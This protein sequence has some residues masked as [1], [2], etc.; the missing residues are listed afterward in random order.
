MIAD[1]I[2]ELRL[3]NGIKQT[4]LAKVL[5]LSRSA[6]NA[7]EMGVSVPS[8]QYLLDLSK[9]FRVST[10]HLLG[11]EEKEMVDVSDLSERDKAI[12]YGLVKR[13]REGPRQ[14]GTLHEDVLYETDGF[15]G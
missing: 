11:R 4:E 12:I 15:D 9:L 14:D 7:W 2:K 10:D 13:L 8:T 5:G 1:R 3:K 6:V